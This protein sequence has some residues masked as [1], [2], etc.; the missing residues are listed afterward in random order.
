MRYVRGLSP[1]KDPMGP[2]EG[3]VRALAVIAQLRQWQD[4]CD[5]IDGTMYRGDLSVGRVMGIVSHRNFTGF[6]VPGS[7]SCL[8]SIAALRFMLRCSWAAETGDDWEV[9][10]EISARVS[11]RLKKWGLWS[12]E[13]AMQFRDGLRTRLGDAQYSLVDLACYTHRMMDS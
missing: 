2:V 9:C 10:R 12:L 7:Y 13:E 6:G 4:L 5:I 8:R 3:S 1:T 11:E